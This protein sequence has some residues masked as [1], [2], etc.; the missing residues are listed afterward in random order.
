MTAPTALQ[1]SL[2]QDLWD[3]HSA[4]DKPRASLAKLEEMSQRVR[5]A[6][7]SAGSSKAEAARV[8]PS[9]LQGKAVSDRRL[10]RL[11]FEG[12][13]AVLC[14]QQ[15]SSRQQDP[16]SPPSHA[17]RPGEPAETGHPGIHSLQGPHLPQQ[18]NSDHKLQ[19][20]IQGPASEGDGASADAMQPAMP[21]GAAQLVMPSR[22][23]SHQAGPEGAL[24]GQSEQARRKQAGTSGSAPSLSKSRIKV[25]GLSSSSL[26][27]LA[28][29]EVA[30][31]TTA[32][33]HIS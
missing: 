10:G 33:L 24:L 5:N 18:P 32:D 29:Q 28:A 8:D 3:S 7:H 23:A 12:Q 15:P 4:V 19:H 17:S 21:G 27:A 20:G 16:V 30:D 14:S 31:C 9:P 22:T 1:I 6:N 26:G 11:H 25:V 2:V 13:V